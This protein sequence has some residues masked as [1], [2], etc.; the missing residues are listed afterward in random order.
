M[1][2]RA[3]ATASDP[4]I[5]SVFRGQSVQNGSWSMR[6]EGRARHDAAT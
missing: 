6:G 4:Q 1:T 5:T 2:F 3:F